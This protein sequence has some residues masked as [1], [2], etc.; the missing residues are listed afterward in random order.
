M[1]TRTE[2]SP[3][4]YSFVSAETSPE[5]ADQDS[6][7]QFCL[8]YSLAAE[9]TMEL[10]A[11]NPELY[12]LYRQRLEDVSLWE[13]P[14]SNL[15]EFA[16]KYGFDQ[17]EIEHYFLIPEQHPTVLKGYSLPYLLD[18]GYRIKTAFDGKNV[19]AA[20]QFIRFGLLRKNEWLGMSFQKQ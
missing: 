6:I 13:P 17:T 19:F 5:K 7:E 14:Q 9:Q 3:E 1:A 11:A 8:H 20:N 15:T 2:F 12:E 10:L 4:Q 18:A 16:R